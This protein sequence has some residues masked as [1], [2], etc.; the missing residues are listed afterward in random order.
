[1][2]TKGFL[3]NIGSVS[4]L[5][6]DNSLRPHVCCDVLLGMGAGY[7]DLFKYNN[8]ISDQNLYFIIWVLPKT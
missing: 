3:T 5:T 1:M 8:D 2:N 4:K 6:D 7:Q